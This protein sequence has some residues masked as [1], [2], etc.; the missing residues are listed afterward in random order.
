MMMNRVMVVAK[1]EMKQIIKN[2]GALLSV[3]IFMVIFGGMTS[4]GALLDMAGSSDEMI[5]VTFN[6]LL[7]SLVM[8]MGVITGYLLLSQA[9]TD[10]KLGGT[11]ET[12]LC[13]PRK[14]NDL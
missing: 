2:R 5:S 8:V 7:L 3:F 4:M 6:S 9:F 14:K 13:S 11:I 10:E 1:K 12:L